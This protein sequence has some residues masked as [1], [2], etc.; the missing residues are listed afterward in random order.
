MSYFFSLP[1]AV[2]EERKIVRMGGRVILHIKI[3]PLEYKLERSKTETH[4]DSFSVIAL[5]VRALHGCAT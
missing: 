5:F 1:R 4:K 3:Y 2:I